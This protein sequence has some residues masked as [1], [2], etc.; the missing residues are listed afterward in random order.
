MISNEWLLRAI[1]ALAYFRTAS[2]LARVNYRDLGTEELGSIYESLLELHPYLDVDSSPWS[3][4]LVGE[5]DGEKTSGS[6][7]RLSGSYY[8]PPGLVAELVKSALEP[9]MIRALAE[10]PN[11]PRK[12]LLELKIVDPACGSGHFML[13]VARR[14]ANELARFDSQSDTFDEMARQHALREVVRHCIFGVDKNELAV[15]LC[16]AA[17]WIETIDPGKPLSFLDPHILKGDSL[18]GILDAADITDG[19]P[20]DAYKPLIGDDPDVCQALRAKNKSS[21][22]KIQGTLFDQERFASR[23]T[24]G[25]AFEDMPEDTRVQI[26]EKQAAWSAKLQTPVR[27]REELKANL[28]VSAFY[29]SKTRGTIHDVPTNEDLAAVDS[30]MT[31]RPEVLQRVDAISRQYAFFHWNVSFRDIMRSGGFDVVIGNPPWKRLKLNEKEFFA[32]RDPSLASMAGKRRKDAIVALKDTNP[33]LWADF[34]AMDNSVDSAN[35]FVRYS[36]RF[37]LTAVGDLN[38]YPLFAETGLRLLPNRG[39]LGMVLRTG[40]ATEETRSAF[41]DKIFAGRQL[42]SLFDFSNANALFSDI[43]Q[44]ERFCLLTVAGESV[45]ETTDFVFLATSVSDLTDPR[46]HFTLSADDLTRIN[47]NTRTCPMFRTSKDAEIAR[48]VY[49]RVPVLQNEAETSGSNKIIELR[50]G[51]FHMTSSS[52]SFE[53]FADLADSGEV[54]NGNRFSHDGSEEWLPL[55]EAKMIDSYDHRYGSYPLG[56]IEDTRALPHPTVSQYQAPDWEPLPRY[57]V[58]AHEV[59]AKLAALGWRHNWLMGF[60]RV[61]RAN[62]GRAVTACVIPKV[63]VGNTIILLL[64]RDIGDPRKSAALLANFCTLTIDYFARQKIGSTDLNV[65]TAKQLPVIPMTWY[66]EEDLDFVSKR[67]LEL[68]YTS[69]SVA[70]FAREL[71]FSGKPFAWQPERRAR[72]QADLDAYFARLYGLERDELRFIL[73]PVDIMGS[74]FPSETFR[75]LKERELRECGEYMTARL[76]IEAWDRLGSKSSK[77]GDSVAY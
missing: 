13:A 12:A 33:R 76:V 3:L 27:Q 40:I 20:D 61:T 18:I 34:V 29:F 7:R 73:D 21:R 48:R 5:D 15:E 68:T 65:F 59:E 36:G 50:E 53:T 47:P 32:R 43:A 16:K 74:D 42:V 46:R 49:S 30:G 8:T 52:G 58:R 2:T 1:H 45:A 69:A 75:V 39:R 63:A 23:A 9:V 24:D 10:R 31:I 28:F 17:L 56:H 57:W 4:R 38:T 44:V 51:L 19:I 6:E 14:I 71:G 66:R 70:P 41:F 67:V 72:L 37:P 54:L 62:Y 22:G 60:R 77:S 26:A 55:Y 35:R 25:V 11:E 64:P